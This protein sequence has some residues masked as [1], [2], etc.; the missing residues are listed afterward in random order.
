MVPEKALW[1][2]NF[3]RLETSADDSDNEVLSTGLRI[4]SSLSLTA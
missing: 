1:D 4:V 3:T 2:V